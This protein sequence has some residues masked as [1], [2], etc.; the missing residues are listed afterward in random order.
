MKKWTKFSKNKKVKCGDYIVILKDGLMVDAS[1]TGDN[2]F[3][4][5]LCAGAGMRMYITNQ[6]EYYFE[7]YLTSSCQLVDDE[8]KTEQDYMN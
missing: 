7:G 8:G 3:Y 5:Y 4:H 1:T 6:V 2:R